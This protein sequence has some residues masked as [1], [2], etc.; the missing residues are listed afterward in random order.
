VYP[1]ARP[2][3]HRMPDAIGRKPQR[4]RP[5]MAIVA[6]RSN[7][8]ERRTCNANREPRIIEPRRPRTKNP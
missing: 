3:A 1:H 8:H 5:R 6:S 4:I 2:A 7:L